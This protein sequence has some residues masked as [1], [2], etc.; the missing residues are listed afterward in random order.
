MILVYVIISY[1]TMYDNFITFT[2][3]MS[4]ICLLIS[5][6]NKQFTPSAID[7]LCLGW[8]LSR[9]LLGHSYL[10]P[11]C[12][13]WRQPSLSGTWYALIIHIAAHK[14][15]KQ[16]N[17]SFKQNKLIDTFRQHSSLKTVR[18][19]ATINVFVACK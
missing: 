15:L 11:N 6:N 8:T 9:K 13:T 19:F 18:N 2:K 4:I 16:I 7:I 5:I 14:G 12:L 17:A 3:R 10:L 1:N